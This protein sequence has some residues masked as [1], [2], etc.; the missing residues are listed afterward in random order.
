M[1]GIFGKGVTCIYLDQFAASNIFD[2]PNN[3]LWKNIADLIQQKAR[4]GKI[5]C[6]VPSEHFLESAAKN[7]QNAMEMDQAF[8]SLAKGWAI[9]SEAFMTPTL[10]IS[11]LR[12]KTPDW[13]SYCVKLK[14]PNTLAHDHYFSSFSEKNTTFRKQIEGRVNGQNVKR[15]ILRQ[16]RFPNAQIEPLTKAMR[17]LSIEPFSKRLGTLI[18]KGSIITQGVETATGPIIDWVDLLIEILLKHHQLQWTEAIQ[19]YGILRQS[20]FDKIPPLNIRSE[21]TINLA[22]HHKKETTNDHVD[23]MRLST[24]LPIADLLFTDKQRKH[25]L[26]E[27][28]LAEKY[29]A[30]VFSGTDADLEHFY[31]VLNQL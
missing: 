11:L 2:Q 9:K 16:K 30:Q 3:S 18:L 17:Y 25:E 6:P 21:L 31:S 19:L 20:G 14:H 13:S 24:G 28:H 15:S 26:T 12:N 8:Y 27:T 5:I 22:K 29:N 23:I 4:Q 7:R 10:I 1:K